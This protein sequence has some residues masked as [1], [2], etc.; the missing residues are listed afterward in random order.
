MI[1]RPSRKIHFP[2]REMLLP[3]TPYRT[4]SLLQTL[5]AH[6]TVTFCPAASRG[7]NPFIKFY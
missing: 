5:L 2:Q 4:I 6:F 1:K 7:K 3:P